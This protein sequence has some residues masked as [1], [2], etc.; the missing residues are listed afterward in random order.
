MERPHTLCAVVQTGSIVAAAGTDPNHQSQF[1][2]QLKQLEEALGTTLFDCVG[3]SIK[4]NGNGRR[5]ALAD[6]TFF[7]A[8][9]NLIYFER[10]RIS[11]TMCANTDPW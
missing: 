1:S 6:Q 8:L 2:R 5:F 9:D 10:V 11:P 4:P 7:G 3:K